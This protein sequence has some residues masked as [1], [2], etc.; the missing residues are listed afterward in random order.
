MISKNERKYQ[1]LIEHGNSKVPE[2]VTSI[3]D[4]CFRGCKELT[5]IELPSS[6]LSIGDEAFCETKISTIT[7]P[8]GV[9]KIELIVLINVHH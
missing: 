1:L 5:S 6:L 4:N 3:G 2:V 9:T 7:I 8:E